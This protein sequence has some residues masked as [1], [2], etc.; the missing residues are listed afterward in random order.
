MWLQLVEHV[1]F[2][3]QDD[4]DP[5]E[6]AE[7]DDSAPAKRAELSDPELVGWTEPEERAD[8]ILNLRKDLKICI[9]FFD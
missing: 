1:G 7:Q 5:A 6:P 9:L 3:E 8:P 4:L 2:E